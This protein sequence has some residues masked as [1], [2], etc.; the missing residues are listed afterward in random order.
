MTHLLNLKNGERHFD[1]ATLCTSSFTLG[2]GCLNDTNEFGYKSFLVKTSC[3]KLE[4]IFSTGKANWWAAG[5][6]NQ[7]L[8]CLNHSSIPK[9]FLLP[10]ASLLK[11]EKPL[12]PPPVGMVPSIKLWPRVFPTWVWGRGERAS[13]EEFLNSWFRLHFGDPGI[14]YHWILNSSEKSQ[15]DDHLLIRL[16]SLYT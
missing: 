16:R 7:F 12:P 1:K 15:P 2:P 4:C 5:K 6:P 9:W 14:P 8:K 10:T 3:L 11:R 13:K